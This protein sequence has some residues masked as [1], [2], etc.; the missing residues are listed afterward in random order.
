MLRFGKGV[1]KHRRLILI[2]SVLLLIPAVIGFLN[3]RINYDILY[4]LPDDIET[5]KGQDILLNDFGK[6]AYGIFVCDGLSTADQIKMEEKLTKVD[7]VASVIC[8]SSLT[9]GEIPAEMLPGNIKD[10]FYSKDGK[11]C[12]MFIFFDS[13]SSSEE[14]MKAIKD[15]RAVAGKQCLLSSMAAVVTDT[16][17]LVQEQT[18]VYTAIAVALALIVL[19]LTMD[20]YI[21]P[22]LFLADIGMTIVYNLG[23]NF[24]TGEMSFITMALVAIL[25][26]G[27]T[28]DYSIFLY[29]S[30]VEQK[31]LYENKED[32]MAHA[33][34]AT[35]TS[36]TGSSLTTIAGFL[37]MCF[38]TFKLGLDM[39][40]VMAKGVVFGVVGCVT[41]LPSMILAC[42]KLIE[43][44]THSF[45]LRLPS[46]GLAKFFDKGYIPAA[47][48]LLL[49]WIPAVYGYSRI[50]VYYKLD[51]SLPETL[52]CVQANK[53]LEK[54]YDMN[55]VCMILADADQPAQETK[56]ML[57]D[58]KNVEGVEF[59]V[60]LDSIQGSLVPD[61]VITF[62]KT[63]EFKSDKYKLLLISSKYQVATDEVNAQCD[64]INKIVK[65]YDSNA[66]FIGEAPATKDLIHMTDR[67]FKVVSAV[68]IGAIFVLILV[69]L[70]SVSIP[71][72]LVT[73]VELAIYLNMSIAYY[74]G[75][76]LPFIASICV[77]TIQLGATIDYAILMTTR[78]KTER[79]GGAGR[80]A[81][82][83]T[84]VESSV[85]S[86]FSSALGFFAATIGCAIYS[87]IDLI[88]SICLLLARGALLSMVLVILLLP[89]L[90]LIFDPVII[91]TTAGMKC[92]VER[93]KNRK[94]VA[95]G[96]IA[97]QI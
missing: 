22:V 12:L 55:S 75:T 37:A 32:A 97:H 73:V 3:T 17:D 95:G 28:M 52:Q 45:T 36:V 85:N 25:Q 57:D 72:I 5:M 27:V 69:V 30:Y 23:S 92:C 94:K 89:A 51:N 9:G 80:K 77:G 11:G 61:D 48:I 93:E 58:I 96:N 67:D 40:I 84:A 74:T 66:M 90:L 63:K 79:I 42:D 50:G 49:C 47:I 24:V 35:L 76:T 38:M 15:V 86:V 46:K 83:K 68:S 7:H 65:A 70:R 82:V 41:I 31:A 54:S 8:Y 88:A 2:L 14:T 59:A 16:K 4:Y 53:A 26:L 33:V 81:A 1:V 19:M 56:K 20:S 87:N 13:T 21:V 62:E 91:R 71:F 64:E 34:S 39:G 60:G 43:K 29:H 78:Y 10:I 6:G 44:T 18:P